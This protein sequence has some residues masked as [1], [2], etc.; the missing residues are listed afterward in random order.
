MKQ[1]FHERKLSE[2]G[3]EISEINESL[4]GL[5]LQIRMFSGQKMICLIAG[6]GIS[7]ILFNLPGLVGELKEEPF[8][9]LGNHNTLRIYC[10]SSLGVG[11]IIIVC[12]SGTEK[13]KIN[14]DE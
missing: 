14:L 6:S 13:I 2:L 11:D 5:F 10:D 1:I 9:L 8:Y 3:Q 12:K 7:K 4:Y